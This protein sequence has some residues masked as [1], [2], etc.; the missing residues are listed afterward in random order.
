[1][2]KEIQAQT[3]ELKVKAEMVFSPNPKGKLVKTKSFFLNITLKKKKN[4][5]QLK[6]KFPLPQA[7]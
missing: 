2:R 4:K 5:I 1:M 3:M 7:A 6:T